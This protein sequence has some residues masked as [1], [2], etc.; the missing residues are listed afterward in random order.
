MMFRFS[1]V[2]QRSG[3]QLSFSDVTRVR[4][5]LIPQTMSKDNDEYAILS[6]DQQ[7]SFS[8]LSRARAP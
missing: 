7:V 6:E 5:N 8:Q 1:V 2:S 3:C 4:Q